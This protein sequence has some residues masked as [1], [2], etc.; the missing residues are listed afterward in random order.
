MSDE[1]PD[2]FL[3]ATAMIS[4]LSVLKTRKA[5]DSLP[6]GK[7]LSVTCA[8]KGSLSDIPELVRRLGHELT[9]TKEQG[10][11]TE[12]HIRKT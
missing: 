5:I 8:D 10:N 7:T 2:M 6:S 12:F 9:A 3:D 1:K 4:P 11:I